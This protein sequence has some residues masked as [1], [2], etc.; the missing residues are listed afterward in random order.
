MMTSG[1]RS[2]GRTV[3]IGIACYDRRKKGEG[4]AVELLSL[5]GLEKR[6]GI[7]IL[8]LVLLFSSLQ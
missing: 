3:W 6:G 1:V 8:A 5:Y 7:F 2:T 4:E